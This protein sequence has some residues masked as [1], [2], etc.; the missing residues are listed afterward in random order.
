MIY[1]INKLPE[2]CNMGTILSYWEKTLLVHTSH[3]VQKKQIQKKG[4]N[5]T[6][7]TQQQMTFGLNVLRSVLGGGQ[8]DQAMA[9]AATAIPPIEG[10]DWFGTDDVRLV[11]REDSDADGQGDSGDINVRPDDAEIDAGGGVSNSQ[12][13][14][15]E[16]II[17][18]AMKTM[19]DKSRKYWLPNIP[20]EQITVP[21]DW[22]DGMKKPTKMQA[23]KFCPQGASDQAR[24]SL[25]RKMEMIRASVFTAWTR[26]YTEWMLN[27]ARACGWKSVRKFSHMTR[28]YVEEDSFEHHNIC[29]EICHG[30][31][32]RCYGWKEAALAVV[33]R[34]VNIVLTSADG[35]RNSW[36]M[37]V[38]SYVKDD[39]CRRFRRSA[40]HCNQR[41]IKVRMSEIDKRENKTIFRKEMICTE[42][43]TRD[44]IVDVNYSRPPENNDEYWSGLNQIQSIYAEYQRKYGDLNEGTRTEGEVGN[45]TSWELV[46]EGSNT[47]PNVETHT[48]A[49]SIEEGDMM[50]FLEQ[51]KGTSFVLQNRLRLADTFHDL[52]VTT[53]MKTDDEGKSEWF[54]RE[55]SGR[56]RSFSYED[57]VERCEMGYY[58]LP[59]FRSNTAESAQTSGHARA[60]SYN[61]DSDLSTVTEGPAQVGRSTAAVVMDRRMSP[62]RKGGKDTPTRSNAGQKKVAGT[63]NVVK[64]KQKTPTKKGGGNAKKRTTPNSALAKTAKNKVGRGAEVQRAGTGNSEKN[65]GGGRSKVQSSGSP[66]SKENRTPVSGTSRG[67]G[68]GS[69]QS[70]KGKSG[71]NVGVG[72]TKERLQSGAAK[73][74]K[75]SAGKQD[76]LHG[77]KVKEHERVE[78]RK[79]HEG[80]KETREKDTGKDGNTGGGECEY[81]HSDYAEGI[82]GSYI[83]YNRTGYKTYVDENDKCGKCNEVYKSFNEKNHPVVCKAFNDEDNDC[84]HSLCS[85]CYG[86]EMEEMGSRGRKRRRKKMD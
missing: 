20:A 24:D 42:H 31:W 60:N 36:V 9:V 79:K 59:G 78:G 71:C 26:V 6:A 3:Q 83:R 49:P 57:V 30:V 34:S 44:F 47:G 80:E 11:D 67:K 2:T 4:K 85:A 84:R 77:G 61:S 53:E 37:K 62:A 8:R 40:K 50:A 82:S 46:E 58:V 41:Y 68:K 55:M 29:F 74:G 72:K 18:E 14:D 17:V 10:E 19:I 38:G 7:T 70:G 32:A 66:A 54:V 39:L 51:K 48:E 23:M 28:K 43:L 5:I 1:C 63:K 21:H 65:K 69:E 25:L 75:T 81:D 64:K 52:E 33:C 16:L 73:G 56:K 76:G 35:C 13:A 86:K 22:I 15:R 27:I 12:H 45:S